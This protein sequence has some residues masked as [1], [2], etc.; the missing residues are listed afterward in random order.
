ME[1]QL[2]KIIDLINSLDIPEDKSSEIDDIKSTVEKL[3][4]EVAAMKK[5]L[6]YAINNL[7]R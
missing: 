3:S 4:K 5:E 6:L 2:D 1:E 7:E